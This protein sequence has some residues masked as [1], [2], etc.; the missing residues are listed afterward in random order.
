MLE[1][2]LVEA[3]AK[4]VEH[5]VDPVVV[6]SLPVTVDKT[7][8]CLDDI[9]RLLAPCDRV[10]LLLNCLSVL[11]DGITRFELFAFLT[12]ALD[13]LRRVADV[14]FVCAAK[15]SGAIK[16]ISGKEF[17]ADAIVPR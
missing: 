17:G 9:S 6:V 15:I 13:G 8:L 12:G 5:V 16:A 4:E 3:P 10:A 14:P 2:G 11:R 1:G 7:L